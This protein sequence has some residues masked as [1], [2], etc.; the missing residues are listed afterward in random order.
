MPLLHLNGAAFFIINSVQKQ[1]AILVRTAGINYGI[2][3]Y[4]HFQP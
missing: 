2:G 1:T 3:S 4:Y